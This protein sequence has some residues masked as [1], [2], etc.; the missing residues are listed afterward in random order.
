MPASRQITMSEDIKIYPST[1]GYTTIL[2]YKRLTYPSRMM[3]IKSF[4][5]LSNLVFK[6]GD[7]GVVK[8][9]GLKIHCA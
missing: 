3:P 8:R 5:T 7:A 9:G 4:K 1:G 6:G 2:G